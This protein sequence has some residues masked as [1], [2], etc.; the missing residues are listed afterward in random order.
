MNAIRKA[1]FAASALTITL[2]GAALV[3]APIAFARSVPLVAHQACS[4]TSVQLASAAE[5]ECTSAGPAAGLMAFN[6]R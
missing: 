5:V 3:T 6:R 2:V 1:A 4:T